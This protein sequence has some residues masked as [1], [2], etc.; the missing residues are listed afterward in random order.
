MRVTAAL[1]PATSPTETAAA[2]AASPSGLCS[3]GRIERIA[4]RRGSY[5]P[6]EH[7][8]PEARAPASD[9]PI[10]KASRQP[11]AEDKC[12]LVQWRGR[13]RIPERNEEEAKKQAEHAVHA[14][15]VIAIARKAIRSRAES[16]SVALLSW[17]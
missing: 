17:P 6:R 9:R 15:S 1:R 16:F 14:Q 11:R 12:R 8:F 2:D 7:R 5:A 10:G 4:G 3:R 13:R